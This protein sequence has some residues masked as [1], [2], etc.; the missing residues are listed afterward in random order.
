MADNLCYVV[1]GYWEDGYSYCYQSPSI[2]D[3]LVIPVTEILPSYLYQEYQPDSDVESFFIAYNGSAQ[4]YL[5]YLVNLNL[6]IW[7]ADTVVGVLL[8]WVAL[9]LYGYHRPYLT[10]PNSDVLNGFYNTVVYD[11]SPPN[12]EGVLTGGDSATLVSDDIFKRCLTWNLY[13]GD[14]FQ[15][16]ARWLKNR[17]LRFLIG[18]NGVAPYIDNTY[19]ISVTYSTG[20]A[21]IINLNNMYPSQIVAILQAAIQ[22]GAIQLP[23]QYIFTVIN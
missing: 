16:D 6:P 1:D 13:K 19:N 17:V 10:Y 21:I 9:G 11:T 3:W 5:T 7:T 4:T 12:N 18:L 20:N 23:F 15:F 8:D 22:Q 2:P 14:G